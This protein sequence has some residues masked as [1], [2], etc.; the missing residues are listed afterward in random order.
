MTQ[1]TA[2]PPVEYLVVV[3]QPCRAAEALLDAIHALW[4]QRYM[5]QAVR[6]DP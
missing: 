3:S 5:P 1:T 4:R 2:P 6:S